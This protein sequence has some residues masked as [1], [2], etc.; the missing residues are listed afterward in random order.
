MM[1]TVEIGSTLRLHNHLK[2]PWTLYP[3]EDHGKHLSFFQISQ[4]D[5]NKALAV[6]ELQGGLISYLKDPLFRI[7]FL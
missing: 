1:A 5:F 7:L 3:G 2:Y 6:E 4:G